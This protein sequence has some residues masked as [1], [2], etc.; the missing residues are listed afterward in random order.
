MIGN[1]FTAGAAVLIDCTPNHLT[2]PRTIKE[3]GMI[4]EM[5]SDAWDNE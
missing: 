2:A 3:K 4:T 1:I 5:G